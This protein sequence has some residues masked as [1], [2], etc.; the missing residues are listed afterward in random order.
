MLEL[1]RRSLPAGVVLEST[2]VHYLWTHS[3]D[4]IKLYQNL[5]LDLYTNGGPKF[6]GTLGRGGIDELDDPSNPYSH[7]M[8]MLNSNGECV[9]G[10]RI[11]TRDPG[12]SYMLPS[13]SEHFLFNH[14]FPNLP[15]NASRTA[16][17]SRLVLMPK[18]TYLIQDIYKQIFDKCME[19]GVH[20][21][22]GTATLARQRV[23]RS[24]CK[25]FPHTNFIINSKYVVP[26]FEK[27]ENVP[28]YASV[29][30]MSQ[31]FVARASENKKFP[32]GSELQ[33]AD[34][35]LLTA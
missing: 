27:Y 15:L 24:V 20:Y 23:Y 16:E 28:M 22:L 31:E 3:K 6:L 1:V 26:D 5:R 17:L 33:N 11:I 9:G 10:L 13:E 7:I 8:V 19:L 34:S 12:E 30:D 29:G 32:Y 25:I 21:L 18:Y 14:A 4:L 2:P 35:V